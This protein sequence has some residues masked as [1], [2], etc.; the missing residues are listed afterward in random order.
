MKLEK[1][2]NLDDGI[3]KRIINRINNFKNE[4]KLEGRQECKTTTNNVLT[5]IKGE[6]RILIK[7][8]KIRDQKGSRESDKYWR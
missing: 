2:Q 8:K 4:D 6:K 7:I 5:E 3:Y 1:S